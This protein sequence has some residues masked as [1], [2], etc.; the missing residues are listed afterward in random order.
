MFTFEKRIV[1]A[2]C[3]FYSILNYSEPL[4]LPDLWLPPASEPLLERAAGEDDLERDPEAD[5][6]REREPDLDLLA[7]DLERFD[8]PSD[9]SSESFRAFLASSSLRAFLVS[10]SLSS[11]SDE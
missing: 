2:F 11:S 7:G 5:R 6:D 10:M 4:P 9:S 1:L 3:L 8:P